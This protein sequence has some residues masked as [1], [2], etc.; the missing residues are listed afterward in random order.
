MIFSRR[1]RKK[2]MAYKAFEALNEL[3]LNMSLIL[4]YAKNSPKK[5]IQA[6]NILK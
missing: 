2:V 4:L 5:H 1:I 6:T 3:I